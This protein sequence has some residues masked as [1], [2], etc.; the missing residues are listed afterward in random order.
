MRHIQPAAQSASS[1]YS[2]FLVPCFLPSASWPSFLRSYNNSY[3]PQRPTCPICPPTTTVKPP[4]S[5]GKGS[6]MPA[7]LNSHEP[8]RAGKFR[9]R[10]PTPESYECKQF[11]IRSHRRPHRRTHRRLCRRLYRSPLVSLQISC[12]SR[13]KDS[14]NT[15]ERSQAIAKRAHCKAFVGAPKTSPRPCE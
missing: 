14:R 11:P 10:P 2:Q 1:K 4:A 3:Y 5:E 8:S 13:A 7:Y 6:H 15:C 9:I 12:G